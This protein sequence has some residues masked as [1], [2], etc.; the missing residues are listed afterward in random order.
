MCCLVDDVEYKQTSSKSKRTIRKVAQGGID[1][2]DKTARL[3]YRIDSEKYELEEPLKVSETKPHTEYLHTFPVVVHKKGKVQFSGTTTYVPLVYCGFPTRKEI[4]IVPG[5]KRRK[6]W[7]P[8][9][10]VP[11]RKRG[12]FGTGILVNTEKQED[13]ANSIFVN[14]YFE[15]FNTDIN[16]CEYFLLEERTKL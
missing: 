11:P 9:D 16:Y 7:S 3:T 15:Q 2:V 13:E 5:T 10:L 8:V 4:L 1:I 14:S 6:K 12:K